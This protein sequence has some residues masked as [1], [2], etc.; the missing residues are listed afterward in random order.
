MKLDT[1]TARLDAATHAVEQRRAA[2]ASLEEALRG[3]RAALERALEAQAGWEEE[4]E[5]AKAGPK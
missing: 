3:E 2:V 1:I 4:L 5:L